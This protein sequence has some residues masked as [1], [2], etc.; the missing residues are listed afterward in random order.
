MSPK[1]VA[2]HGRSISEIISEVVGS[3]V[4]LYPKKQWTV[5]SWNST[6]QTETF[7]TKSINRVQ[8]KA[9]LIWHILKNYSRKI[10]KVFDSCKLNSYISLRENHFVYT[11]K[12]WKF[13]TYN[14]LEPRN[15]R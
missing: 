1:Y 14:N 13:I 11:T 5:F 7:K 15:F 6:T 3:S 12:T 8:S 9:L 2:Q 4:L 10:V